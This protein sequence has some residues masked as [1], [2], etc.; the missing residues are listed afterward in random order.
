MKNH[1]VI[2]VPVREYFSGD[3]INGLVELVVTKSVKARGVQLLFRG[4]EHGTHFLI[5]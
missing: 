1:L 5:I 3:V 2:H 4:F